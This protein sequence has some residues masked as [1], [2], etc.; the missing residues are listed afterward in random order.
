MSALR[1]WRSQKRRLLSESVDSQWPSAKNNPHDKGTYF[2]VAYSDPSQQPL[3]W[4][5]CLC[6][7]RA[8]EIPQP[9]D[10]D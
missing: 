3:T 7:P 1:Y 4:V 6:N 10:D 9:I 8:K 2:E 5:E